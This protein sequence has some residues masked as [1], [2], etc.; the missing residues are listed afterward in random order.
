MKKETIAKNWPSL[1]FC[2][3]S[4]ESETRPTVLGLLSDLF[5]R[6]FCRP[7]YSK[8]R[9]RYTHF[10]NSKADVIDWVKKIGYDTVILNDAPRGGITGDIVVLRG[11]SENC[12]I[13]VTVEDGEVYFHLCAYAFTT[14]KIKVSLYGENH[15]M[16]KFFE[17]C[18]LNLATNL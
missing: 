13:S 14:K 7:I 5:G 18:D 1:G 3:E 10:Y 8:G 12:R 11:D 16:I 2:A 6:G 4:L 15:P 17:T 9:G